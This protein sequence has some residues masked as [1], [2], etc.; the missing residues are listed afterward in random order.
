MTTTTPT[1][2]DGR[3]EEAI[4]AIE[5]EALNEFIHDIFSQ[6]ASALNNA[7][8]AAQL[9]YLRSYWD[10]DERLLQNLREFEV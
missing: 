10:D 5:A 1:T 3:L 9:A 7:G 2:M 8:R 4:E 6:Q